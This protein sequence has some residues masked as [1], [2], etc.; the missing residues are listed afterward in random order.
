MP[1]TSA[2]ALSDPLWESPKGGYAWTSC[3]GGC[4]GA[5]EAVRVHH[6]SKFRLHNQTHHD[7]NV[8]LIALCTPEQGLD[9]AK[10]QQRCPSF[11][12]LFHIQHGQKLSPAEHAGALKEIN[13]AVA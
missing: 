11:H 12:G 1:C 8:D 13:S 2:T 4:L 7:L 9:E 10:F 3:P 5:Q 6:A